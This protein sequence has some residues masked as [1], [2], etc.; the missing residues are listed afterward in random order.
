MNI[1]TKIKGIIYGGNFVFPSLTNVLRNNAPISINPNIAN[2]YGAVFF[3]GLD[4]LGMLSNKI[5]ESTF[6]RLSKLAGFGYYTLSTLSDLISIAGG[7]YGNFTH[8]PFDVSI[9]YQL[10]KDTFSSYSSKKSISDDIVSVV[11]SVR[12]IPQKIRRTKK[13]ILSP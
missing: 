12:E 8:L 7:D 4:L 5:R 11:K 9:A 1:D 10:G 13:E 3:G 2:P 6:T